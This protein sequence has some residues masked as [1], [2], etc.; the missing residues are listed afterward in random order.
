MIRLPPEST[1]TDTLFPYTTLF[2]STSGDGFLVGAELEQRGQ[3]HAERTEL[4]A[5]LA[6]DQDIVEV[7]ELGWSARHAQRLKHIDIASG[8]ERTRR[9]HPAHH[10]KLQP[11]GYNARDGNLGHSADILGAQ[12]VCDQFFDLGGQ[13]ALTLVLHAGRPTSP[14]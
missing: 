12:T 13:R 5:R 11:R 4:R 2:R 1:R 7:R 6:N 8:S 9:F 10:R 14:Q 3:P